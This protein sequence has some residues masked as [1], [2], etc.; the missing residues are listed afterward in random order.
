MPVEPVSVNILDRD[1][2]I[3][4]QPEERRALVEAALYLDKQMRDVRDSGKLTSMEKIAVM[5]ALNMA[6]E[7]LKSRQSGM[8]RHQ[9][10][11]G[12]IGALADRLEN[13]LA[14]PS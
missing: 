10:V 5:C 13:A 14:N 12:R 1:Y 7:L 11:D 3:A 6:D 9:Q 2:R 4:C 8:D